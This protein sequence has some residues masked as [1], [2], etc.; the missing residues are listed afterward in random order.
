MAQGHHTSSSSDPLSDLCYIDVW[1]FAPTTGVISSRNVTSQTPLSHELFT[2]WFDQIAD[3]ESSFSTTVKAGGLM[4]VVEVYPKSGA[5][6]S[7][8]RRDK[9]WGRH[10]GRLVQTEAGPS[11]V[12]EWGEP[13]AGRCSDT[14]ELSSDGR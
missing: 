1:V 4:D 7:H 11:I 10:W 9:R 12:V 5:T 8:A 14:F 13:Y 3:T 6:V 2:L